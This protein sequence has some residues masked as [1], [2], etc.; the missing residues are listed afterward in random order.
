MATES[1]SETPEIS[2][3]DHSTKGQNSWETWGRWT[4]SVSE[5]A[6]NGEIF[7]TRRLADMG[8]GSQCEISREIVE[9]EFTKNYVEG[10]MTNS[11]WN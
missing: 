2:S 5:E 9:R 11:D 1:V 4:V 7:I 8:F 10:N 3:E 6:Q